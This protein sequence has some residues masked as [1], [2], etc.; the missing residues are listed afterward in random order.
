MP[1]GPR[2]VDSVA[3]LGFLSLNLV[4]GSSCPARGWLFREGGISNALCELSEMAAAS[5][6]HAAP[7]LLNDLEVS[8][9]GV[10][11]RKRCEI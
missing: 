5:W 9:G 11:S 7:Y 10:G 6:M 8:K 1:N 2:R 4:P 3:F